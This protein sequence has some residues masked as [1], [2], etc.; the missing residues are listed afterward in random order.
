MHDHWDIR[1]DILE[2]FECLPRDLLVLHMPEV[3]PAFCGWNIGLLAAFDATKRRDK[4]RLH[5]VGPAGSTA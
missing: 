5:R 3:L 1:E 2:E 4:V